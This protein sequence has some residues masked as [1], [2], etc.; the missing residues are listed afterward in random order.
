VSAL[1]EFQA[2]CEMESR[3]QEATLALMKKDAADF[4]ARQA[5]APKVN[6]LDYAEPWCHADCD[7]DCIWTQCPQTRDNEPATFGRHCPLDLLISELD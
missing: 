4:E 3:E 2:R 5:M 7:G 6:P 1:S